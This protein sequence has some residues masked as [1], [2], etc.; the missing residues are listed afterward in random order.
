[1]RGTG[2]HDFTITDA[3]VPD[4]RVHGAV[5]GSH[6]PQPLYQFVG[7]THVAHAAIGLGI[8]RVA[9][10]ALIALAGGKLATWHASEGRLAT[11]T[12]IQAKVAR[13]EALIGS[14]RAY[15]RDATGDTWETVSRG[16]RPSPTQRAIFRL[17]IAHAMD[18]ALEA[19]DLVYR[20]GGA[21]SIY[22]EGRLDRCL[23][24]VHTAAAHVWVAPDT[25]ELAGRLLLGLD[26]GSPNI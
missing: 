3:F 19:V 6:R 25:Y 12:T 24:D 22:A 26:P 5:E 14:G 11:R 13:A 10:D 4:E 2:S 8:A 15:V 1:M 17:A 23:R 21:T 16:E 7:W 9:L 18:N 20:V